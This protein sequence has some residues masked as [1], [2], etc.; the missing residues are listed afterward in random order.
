ME[1]RSLNNYRSIIIHDRIL[2]YQSFHDSSEVGSLEWT[3]FYEE[4]ETITR[5]KWFFF[6]PIVTFT[7]PKV[8]FKIYANADNERLTKD[9]WREK[10]AHQLELL[11]RKEQIKNGELI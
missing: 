1:S 3:E 11:E 2:Y 8:L 10:I 4:I 7:R 9:W 5:K 6:G